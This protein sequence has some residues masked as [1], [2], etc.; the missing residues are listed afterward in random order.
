MTQANVLIIGGG[1]MGSACA[2]FLLQADPGLSV[3]VIKPDPT[4][5]RAASLKASGGVRRLFALSEN[6][7]MSQFSIDWF[8]HFH[9]HVAVGGEAPDLNW[10]QGG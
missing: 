7:Q 4:Y 10:K 2:T 8:Q 1:V 5:E 3:T 9:N 6:I